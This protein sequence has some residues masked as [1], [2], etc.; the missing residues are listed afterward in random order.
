MHSAEAVPM[1]F[2]EPYNPEI[3]TSGT[4]VKRSMHSAEADPI[5]FLEPY[6]PEISTS[7]TEVKPSMHTLRLRM[8]HTPPAS[9]RLP[10]QAWLNR[11]KGGRR[12][13]GQWTGMLSLRLR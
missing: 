5:A 10:E 12:K 6:N 11:G 1:A 9:F 13:G 4:E 3:R 2:L 8:F 7:G